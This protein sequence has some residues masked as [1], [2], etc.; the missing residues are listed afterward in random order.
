[1][2]EL[3]RVYSGRKGKSGS[4]RPP[5]KMKPK[6]VK[7]KKQDVEK[8]V[9]KLAKER[10]SSALIGTILRDKYGIPDVKL[11]TGKSIVQ[12]MKEN[13]LYPALPEDMLNLLKKAV[14]LHDHLE[15]N[16]ADKH[17]KRGLE[18]LESMIRRLAKYY[19]RKKILPAGWKYS[20][21]EA[22]LIVQK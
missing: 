11:I 8:L 1:V 6:W 12:M 3:A 10:Y 15:K 20:Y 7:E 16:K 19:I 18:N 14:S 13:K 9:I 2:S 21:E 4:K 22:K 17:S 5:V